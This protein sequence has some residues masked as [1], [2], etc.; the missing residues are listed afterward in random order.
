MPTFQMTLKFSSTLHRC[1]KPS[2]SIIPDAMRSGQ[3]VASTCYSLTFTP[4]LAAIQKENKER[5]RESL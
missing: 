5:D 2:A 3:Y 4:Y 1:L